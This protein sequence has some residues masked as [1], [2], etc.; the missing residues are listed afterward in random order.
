MSNNGGDY[1]ETVTIAY[2]KDGKAV[3]VTF[4]SSSDFEFCSK[5]GRYQSNCNCESTYTAEEIKVY[6]MFPEATP[7]EHAQAWF[8]AGHFAKAAK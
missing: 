5:C 8:N 4:E 3:G 2:N 6:E 1:T 7:S